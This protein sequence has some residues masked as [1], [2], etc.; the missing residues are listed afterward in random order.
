MTT[1][2]NDDEQL[3][4]EMVVHEI[5]HPFGINAKY[6]EFCS[7]HIQQICG[8]VILDREGGQQILLCI[9]AA[10]TVRHM[11]LSVIGGL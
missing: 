1:M 2:V 6:A 9:G 7:I 10:L 5:G 11:L 3:Q 8:D 4:N